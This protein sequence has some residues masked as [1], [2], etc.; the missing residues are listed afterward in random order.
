MCGKNVNK[1]ERRRGGGGAQTKADAESEEKAKQRRARGQPSLPLRRS[2][3]TGFISP[4]LRR[5]LKRD[6]PKYTN[7]TCTSCPFVMG[8]LLFFPPFPESLR[9]QS[10]QLSS[11]ELRRPAQTSMSVLLEADRSDVLLMAL[12]G[13]CISRQFCKY[14][15]HISFILRVNSCRLLRDPS[16]VC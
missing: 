11:V 14:L 10:G 1:R 12:I 7:Y 5:A 4:Q 6:T 9:T 3:L 16:A 8:I 2:S 15:I 13:H